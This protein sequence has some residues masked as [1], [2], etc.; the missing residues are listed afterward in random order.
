M[1]LKIRLM[2]F[3]VLIG[4]ILLLMIEIGANLL[5]VDNASND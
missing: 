4:F 3:L 1:M 5:L 2:T